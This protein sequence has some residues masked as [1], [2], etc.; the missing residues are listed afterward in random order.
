[1]YSTHKDSHLFNENNNNNKFLILGYLKRG[2]VF[3][4]HSSINDLSNPFAI[5]AFS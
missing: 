5:E 1:M 4:E 3:G 2:D